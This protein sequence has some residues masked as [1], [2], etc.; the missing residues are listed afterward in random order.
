MSYLQRKI[1]RELWGMK[2]RSMLIISSIAFAIGPY[3]GF[4]L[5]EENIYASLWD[6]YDQLD[7]EDASFKFFNYVN[8][9]VLENLTKEIDNIEVFDSRLSI[10]SSIKVDG[11]DFN[12]QFI[13]INRS[14]RPLVNN[15]KLED[16]EFFDQN[17]IN[18]VIIETHFASKQKLGVGDY[19]SVVYGN[20]SASLKICGVAFS[21][22]YKY[23]VNPNSGLPEIGTFCPIWIPLDVLQEVLVELLGYQDN[24]INEFLI[25]VIDNNSLDETINEVKTYLSS[26]G[27]E[28][29]A[30]RGDDELD[31]HFME[32][33]VGLISEFGLAMGLITLLVAV[34][35]I[36]DS[37]VK[38][39]ISQRKIIGIMRAL[40]A[41]K[42][43]VINHYMIYGLI[44]T[45]LGSILS[46]PIGY[47]FLV[48]MRNIYLELIGLPFVTTVFRIE[49]FIF[50]IFLG[51][52]VSLFSCFIAAYKSSTI[53]PKDAM[54]AATVTSSFGRKTFAEKIIEP[55]SKKNKYS[56]KIPIRHVFNRRRR[57]LLSI[58]T[59]ALSMLMIIATLGS[60]DSIIKQVDVYYDENLPYDLEGIL[61]TPINA[62]TIE[63]QLEQIEGIDKAEGMVRQEV[64]LNSQ[65]ANKSTSLGAYTEGSTMRN[66]HFKEGELNQGQIILGTVLA[67]ELNI[68]INEQLVI[69]TKGYGGIDHVNNSFIVSGILA[70]LI[71]TEV[72]MLLEDAQ[73]FLG[74]GTNVTSVA[75]TLKTNNRQET[76]E[77]IIEEELPF[78]TII[79]IKRTKESVM[80]LM[81]G[82]LEVMY[83]IVFGG[84]IILITFSLNAIV[85]DIIERE[86][87]FVN[88][89]TGG[90]STGKIAKIIGLQIMI[91]LIAVMILQGPIG[92]YSTKWI[93]QKVVTKLFYVTTYLKPVTY[94]ITSA[95]LI[96]GLGVGVIVSIRHAMKISLVMITRMRFQT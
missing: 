36:Y 80:D 45:V 49:P 25:K 26:L 69:T 90:A 3:G 7:Y 94:V 31:Q 52:S 63:N 33:D 88:L 13:G 32:V 29:A 96:I 37:L 64:V 71:D 83:L 2:W 54:S 24:L 66:Y 28:I 51:L 38:L 75:M 4:A 6:T 55:I 22:E 48:M 46:L 8:A 30:T 10:V 95:S 35:I 50:P 81:Q 84:I 62:S 11:D 74:L 27:L 87:E 58:I 85:L 59:I 76:I 20:Y 57:T 21:P 67:R 12:S 72:F 17:S 77:K 15:F 16:G 1:F 18:E 61:I 9:E 53:L 89:R 19:L 60:L 14:R 91:I 93:N 92:H 73:S 40:G 47:L 56:L 44:L 42:W 43:K 68:S 39:I 65:L 86:A 34:F 78:A 79:D 70:E 82:I 5:V 41:S 23:V